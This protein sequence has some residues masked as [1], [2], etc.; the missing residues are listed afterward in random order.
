MC[1][2]S[3]LL[4]GI[5]HGF[6]HSRA[7]LWR[8]LGWIRDRISHRTRSLASNSGLLLSVLRLLVLVLVLVLA[9]LLAVLPGAFAAA[10]C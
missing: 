9:L 6:P 1:T 5:L 4:L 7:K 3:Y 8:G 2:C 10:S